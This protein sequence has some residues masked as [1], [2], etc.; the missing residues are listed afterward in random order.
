M[1]AA[2][3]YISLQKLLRQF[4]GVLC[5]SQ[6]KTSVVEHCIAT[7]NASPIRLIPYR[8]LHAYRDTVKD[9]L[10]EMEQVGIIEPS[11]S[12]WPAPIIRVGLPREILTDQG[13]N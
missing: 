2:G 4:G 6:G 8:L 5:R 3:F 7:N 1:I 12:P 13:S 9:E 10:K 11:S